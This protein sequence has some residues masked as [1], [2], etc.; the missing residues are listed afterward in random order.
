MGGIVSDDTIIALPAEIQ[1]LCDESSLLIFR[2][3]F[4]AWQ[5]DD[6]FVWNNDDGVILVC[7]G[8]CNIDI[9]GGAEDDFRCMAMGRGVIC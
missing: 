6:H 8:E 3:G 1:S 9:C 5:E 2:D 7:D 4:H